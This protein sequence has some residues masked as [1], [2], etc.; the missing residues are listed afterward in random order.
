MT[1]LIEAARAVV[2]RWDSPD[3]SDAAHTRDYI[4]AL[5]AAIEAAESAK[6]AA[7]LHQQDETG[8]F[9][10]VMRGEAMLMDNRW[11]M[12]GPLYLHP[13][14]PARQPMTEREIIGGFDVL[15]EALTFFTAFEAGVRHAERHH[16][17]GVKTAWPETQRQRKAP[18][19]EI[20][21]LRRVADARQ[22]I[23]DG[24]IAER[25]AKQDAE[26][27]RPLADWHE[28]DGAV[29]WWKI[30]VDE[31]AWIGTPLD[32]GW[33]GYHTHWTPHPKPPERER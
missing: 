12:V 32:D 4:D 23:I 5:R 27:P 2:A 24:M 3:W 22:Q 26:M 19:T 7:M 9:Q 14:E 30:P 29:V 1:D 20:T 33:P 25:C 8:R 31:P 6:P 28:D 18:E 11:I 10:V 13:P 17:I 15:P 21:F 16:G